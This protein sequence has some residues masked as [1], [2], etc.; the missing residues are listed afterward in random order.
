MSFTNYQPSIKKQNPSHIWH[1][2]SQMK[3][4][5][6]LEP[7]LIKSARGSYIELENGKKIIDAISSWW[8]K[9]LGHNHPYIKAKVIEQINK[10]EHV[11]LANTINEKIIELS[12]KIQQS[13]LDKFDIMIHPEVNII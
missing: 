2:C 9:L 8:C 12:K 1:P 7:M 3:D 5:I 6:N 11:I 10:F 4:Y 13:V